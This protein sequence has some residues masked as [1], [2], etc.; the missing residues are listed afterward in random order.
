MKNILLTPDEITYIDLDRE[1]NPRAQLNPYHLKS[2]QAI[3]CKGKHSTLLYTL[4]GDDE[5]RTLIGCDSDVGVFVDALMYQ[6]DFT[7]DKFLIK[8]GKKF[9]KTTRGE[10]T[11]INIDINGNPK[12]IIRVRRGLDIRSTKYGEEVREL[13]EEFLNGR[14]DILFA[15][16][17]GTLASLTPEMYKITNPFGFISLSEEPIP[18]C[19]S[20]SLN[21]R[22]FTTQQSRWLYEKG[23][24]I[25]YQKLEEI[26]REIF[27]PLLELE[28]Y[29]FGVEDEEI[30][31]DDKIYHTTYFKNRLDA[32]ANTELNP[33]LFKR[34][35]YGYNKLLLQNIS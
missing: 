28:K 2:L 27:V 25:L 30:P 5:F 26:E 14:T 23:R 9:S 31:K 17:D 24:T 22:R 16:N 34:V 12:R 6:E 18:R 29:D 19:V 4:S 21:L 35:K 10:V 13:A 33:R 3:S 7:L 8:S 20:T 1:I 15:D 32:L 11:E